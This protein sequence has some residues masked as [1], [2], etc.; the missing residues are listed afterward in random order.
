MSLLMSVNDI[1]LYVTR[2]LKYL[3]NFVNSIK[4]VNDTL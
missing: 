2:D 4:I 3:S 1:V